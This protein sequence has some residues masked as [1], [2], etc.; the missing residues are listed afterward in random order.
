MPKQRMWIVWVMVALVVGATQLAARIYAERQAYKTGVYIGKSAFAAADYKNRV[1]A[2]A[3]PVPSGCEVRDLNNDS[4]MENA[5][6][7][8][9]I[10]PALAD[11]APLYT[12]FRDGWR[13]ARAAALTHE[14]PVP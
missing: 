9:H 5:R 11:S 10:I 2:S 3:I 12:G 7:S 8:A 6:A 4:A 14:A 13:D 1:C